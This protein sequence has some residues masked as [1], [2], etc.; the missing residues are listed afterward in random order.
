MVKVGTVQT[1][2]SH[3][4][5]HRRRDGTVLRADVP[6]TDAYCPVK[7]STVPSCLPQHGRHRKNRNLPL[8]LAVQPANVDA[9]RLLEDPPGRDETQAARDKLCAWCMRVSFDI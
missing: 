9:A 5:V 1:D 6:I 2:P 8:S 7:Y 3:L 4:A